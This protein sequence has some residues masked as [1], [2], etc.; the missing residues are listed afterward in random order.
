ML[1]QLESLAAA[2]RAE[3]EQLTSGEALAAWNSRTIGRKGE[4]TQM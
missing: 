1:D 2:A 3:L 4:I